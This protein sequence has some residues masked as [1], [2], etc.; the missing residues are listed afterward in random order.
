M[1]NV[2]PLDLFYVEHASVFLDMALVLKTAVEVF[3]HSAA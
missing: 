2:L 3:T 1:A